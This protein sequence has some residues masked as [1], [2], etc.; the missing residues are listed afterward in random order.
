MVKA[1]AHA[2]PPFEVWQ[3]AE[4]NRFDIASGESASAR[5]RL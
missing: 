4:D 3:N 5:A 1:K 2:S